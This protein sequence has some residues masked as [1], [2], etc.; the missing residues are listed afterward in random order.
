M[1]KKSNSLKQDKTLINVSTK[2]KYFTTKSSCARSDGVRW[3]TNKKVI[4][5]QPSVT[6]FSNYRYKFLHVQ[7]PFQ[8]V[9]KKVELWKVRISTDTWYVLSG[10]KLKIMLHCDIK[11]NKWTLVCFYFLCY[12]S[13]KRFTQQ[14]TK[15][16]ITCNNSLNSVQ[17]QKYHSVPQICLP[18][19]TP[20]FNLSHSTTSSVILYP[21]LVLMG[22]LILRVAGITSSF[23]HITLKMSWLLHRA[24]WCRL[25]SCCRATFWVLFPLDYCC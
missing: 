4:S 19:P 15:F 6:K 3:P 10:L 20:F 25:F 7:Q 16:H 13:T 23:P 2:A 24:R 8:K 18:P 21:S 1:S 5:K 9:W 17:W 12:I 22:G 11:P 14:L